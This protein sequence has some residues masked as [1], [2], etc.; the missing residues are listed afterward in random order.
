MAG[1]GPAAHIKILA[2]GGI[3]APY[4][5]DVIP[6]GRKADPGPS[7]FRKSLDSGPHALRAFARND[8]KG[9]LTPPVK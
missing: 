6:G 8:I 2:P 4:V 5:F 3:A 9:G 1:S 7:D